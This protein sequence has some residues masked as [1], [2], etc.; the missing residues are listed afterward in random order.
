MHSNVVCDRNISFAKT[1]ARTTAAL[2]VQN[3]EVS[4]IGIWHT[5]G[6]HGNVSTAELAF[7]DLSVTLHRPWNIVRGVDSN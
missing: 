3:T 7:L 1:V 2:R 4:V 6:R 5:S